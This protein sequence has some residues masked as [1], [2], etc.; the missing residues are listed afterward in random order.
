M[1]ATNNKAAP[2]PPRPQLLPE[3]LRNFM[4]EVRNARAHGKPL[5][6]ADAPPAIRA[7]SAV[8]LQ[9]LRSHARFRS[10]S[11][12]FL[13]CDSSRHEVISLVELQVC[14]TGGRGLLK[15]RV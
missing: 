12:L 5:S 14:I 11:D 9:R 3:E 6:F 7:I 1:G 4:R 2:R 8:F 13:H 15:R 10:V